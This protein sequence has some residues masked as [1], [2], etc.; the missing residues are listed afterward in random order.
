VDLDQ[1]SIDAEEVKLAVEQREPVSPFK[2]DEE[3]GRDIVSRCSRAETESRT[4][5][6][7]P[8]DGCS[9]GQRL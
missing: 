3:F 1:Y 9:D 4:P 5:T 8:Y 6:P 7:P 2:T